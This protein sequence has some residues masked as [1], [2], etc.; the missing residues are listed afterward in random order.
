MKT[1]RELL[2]ERIELA[3]K[4]PEIAFQGEAE[5]DKFY[6]AHSPEKML[7]IY[8]ALVKQDEV[9]DKIS[10]YFVS[11]DPG[12]FGAFIGAGAVDEAKKA[13]AEILKILEGV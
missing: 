6:V 5:S 10:N 3:E 8:E 12:R 1:L 2:K 4:A 7:K 9:L 13:R 11:Y